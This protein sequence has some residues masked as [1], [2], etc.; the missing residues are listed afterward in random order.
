MENASI[1]KSI[2]SQQF[3]KSNDTHPVT[4]PPNNPY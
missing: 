2:N 4:I 3:T 1:Y